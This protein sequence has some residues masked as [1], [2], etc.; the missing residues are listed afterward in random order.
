ML[1][2]R[3]SE[4][5]RVLN[6]SKSYLHGMVRRGALSHRETVTNKRRPVFMLDVQEIAILSQRRIDEAAIKLGQMRDGHEKLLEIV[7]SEVVMPHSSSLLDDS[8]DRESVESPE[9]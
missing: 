4:A 8:A 5:A 3:M 2:I 7:S 6:V 9:G 1:E